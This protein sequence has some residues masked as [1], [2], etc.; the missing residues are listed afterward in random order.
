M[1]LQTHIRGDDL[2]EVDPERTA[3]AFIV[4]RTQPKMVLQAS[5]DAGVGEVVDGN[6]VR[7]FV[8]KGTFHA[9]F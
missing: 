8:R 6:T 3:Q 4:I 7:C 5:V 1:Q 2:E 9:L